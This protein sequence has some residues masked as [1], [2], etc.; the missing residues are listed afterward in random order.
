MEG[1]T[2]RRKPGARRL[3]CPGV[4]LCLSLEKTG[5]SMFKPAK[6]TGTGARAADRGVTVVTVP[7][8]SELEIAMLEL[9]EAGIDHWSARS[10]RSVADRLLARGLVMLDQAPSLIDPPAVRY[11]ITASG[12]QSLAAVRSITE[13]PSHWRQIM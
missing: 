12:L 8:L 2:K 5:D 9:L 11:R 13:R 4:A 3:N 10:S 6:R 7:F 1:L